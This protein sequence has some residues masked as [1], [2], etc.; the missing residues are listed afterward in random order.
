M[1][2]EWREVAG[3]GQLDFSVVIAF[4]N[5]GKMGVGNLYR[6]KRFSR[7]D[8]DFQLFK[9]YR[10][11][12]DALR[13][14]VDYERIVLVAFDAGRGNMVFPI[15]RLLL[16]AAAFSGVDHLPHRV[17][18]VVGVQN[19]LAVDVPGGPSRSLNQRGGGAQEANEIDRREDCQR[20]FGAA[21]GAA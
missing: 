13:G 1:L 15:V 21:A 12:L 14:F 19:N 7:A 5:A 9:F 20:A 18:N 11:A 2:R 8:L 6:A 17:G 4:V 3:G 16:C 10:P